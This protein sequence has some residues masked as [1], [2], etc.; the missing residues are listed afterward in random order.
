MTKRRVRIEDPQLLALRDIQV[1]APALRTTS[2]IAKEELVGDWVHGKSWL[3]GQDGMPSG[4]VFYGS[5]ESADLRWG[6]LMKETL[7]V[8]EAV[9]HTSMA[10]LWRL[11]QDV[12]KSSAEVFGIL[13]TKGAY[14]ADDEKDQDTNTLES[15]L[16]VFVDHFDLSFSASLPEVA[17]MKEFIRF[18]AYFAS[19][20]VR[21]DSAR[22]AENIWT[23]SFLTGLQDGTH[24]KL[25]VWE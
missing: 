8:G 2:K 7:L 22:T 9:C 6:L 15:G 13:L 1:Y 21:A 24:G 17:H 12:G 20:Y 18:V 16:H 11:F 10:E 4:I 3:P 14:P 23:R 25:S 19:L 5:G